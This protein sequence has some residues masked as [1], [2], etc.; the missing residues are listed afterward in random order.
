MSVNEWRSTGNTS[1][2]YEGGRRSDCAEQTP[3][4]TQ[5][6]HR[7]NC[8]TFTFRA[9]TEFDSAR[10]RESLSSDQP[11]RERRNSLGEK[12]LPSPAARDSFTRINHDLPRA[13]PTQNTGD[14]LAACLFILIGRKMLKSSPACLEFSAGNR[15]WAF[16]HTEALEDSC[17]LQFQVRQHAVSSYLQ[18]SKG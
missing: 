12:P 11:L 7:H 18:S 6:T 9:K 10:L 13:I 1:L 15:K 5:L 8:S 16:F 4:N 17:N 14:F 3:R 2:C